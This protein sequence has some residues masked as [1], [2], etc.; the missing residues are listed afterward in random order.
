MHQR[1]SPIARA[2]V[3]GSP[4]DYTFTGYGLSRIQAGRSLAGT[5]ECHSG[6]TVALVALIETLRDVWE[7]C[8]Q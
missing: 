3:F 6:L 7:S 2:P 4:W 8:R 5:I 1:P